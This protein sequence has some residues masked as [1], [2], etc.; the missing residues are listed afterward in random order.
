[1]RV[2]WESFTLDFALSL[3][4]ARRST[5][6]ALIKP[7]SP[8][9]PSWAARTGPVARRLAARTA[10]ANS[11]ER[12]MTDL[13]YAAS[14][15]LGVVAVRDKYVLHELRVVGN[16]LP[17]LFVVAFLAGVLDDALF[18]GMGEEVPM[19]HVLV[20]RVG[21]PAVTGIAAVVVIAGDGQ[22]VGVTGQ[23]HPLR[24]PHPLGFLPHLVGAGGRKE[25]E[26][27]NEA[28]GDIS[29]S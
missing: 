22:T 14:R 29:N 1:M 13:R 6:S 11:S 27:Q 24:S 20:L 23:A 15:P 26:R 21:L 9:G 16:V 17:Q 25:G 10:D 19:R 18:L 3:G 12:L 28:Q 7:R 4:S 5:K 8:L 2:P